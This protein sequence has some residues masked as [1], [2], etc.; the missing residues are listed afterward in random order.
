MLDSLAAYAHRFRR[1]GKPRQHPLEHTFM[2]LRCV[3]DLN[4]PMFQIMSQLGKYI[5]IEDFK[6]CSAA[7]FI[8]DNTLELLNHATDR[9][10][11][12]T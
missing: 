7:W 1:L 4:S 5:R 6:C 10:D 8:T 3:S 9:H 11:D 12:I 2:L